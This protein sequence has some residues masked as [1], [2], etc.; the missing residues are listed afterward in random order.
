MKKVYLDYNIWQEMYKSEE[1]RA[2]F[3]SKSDWEYYISVAHFEELFH[4]RNNESEA[5]K[6]YAEVLRS[7]MLQLSK[8]GILKPAYNGV[9]FFD[10]DSEIQ[11]AINAIEKEH[12]TQE[13]IKT[14]ASNKH[15]NLQN[16][17]A[18]NDIEGVKQE[19][20]YQKIWEQEKVKNLIEEYNL[21]R[22]KIRSVL[23]LIEARP[24]FAIQILP[25]SFVNEYCKN[26]INSEIIKIASQNI[27]TLSVEIQAQSFESIKS[28]YQALE[29]IIDNMFDILDRVGFRRD[30][31]ERTA[32]S[33]I[34]DTQHSIMATHCDVFITK[35]KKFKERFKA[36]AWY[37]GIPIKIMR[38]DG[39]ELQ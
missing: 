37:L 12:D 4:A 14:F 32:I 11:I 6:G 25:E 7:L 1:T 9:T 2:Y 26:G 23:P 28:N 29:N 13:T 33:G 20:L 39:K 24:E 10:R 3:M 34:Y 17:D 18:I 22:R 19:D 27:E 15:S 8:H 21:L 16:E 36:V 38:W 35:D 5:Y 30:K 31:K